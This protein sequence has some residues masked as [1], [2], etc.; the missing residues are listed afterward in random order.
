MADAYVAKAMRACG[1]VVLIG[2]IAASVDATKSGFLQGGRQRS[3]IAGH[4][5]GG[6]ENDGEALE[7]ASEGLA[8]VIELLSTMLKQFDEQ[9]VSD[10]TNWEEYSAW[11][12]NAE[13]EK[14]DFLQDQKALVMASESSLASNKQEVAK[15]TGDLAELGKEIADEQK[16]LQGLIAMRKEEHLQFEASLADVTKTIRAVVKAQEILEGHYATTEA[17]LG[18]IR[19]RVQMALTTYASRTS[20]ATPENERSLTSFLQ[21][22][23]RGPDFLNADGSKYEKYEKQGG[24]KGVLGLLADLQSQLESKKQD[25]MG[26]ETDARRQFEETK[27]S[28][29]ESLKHMHK[30]KGEKTAK[31]AECE[32]TIE[33]CIA[34]LDQAKKEIEDAKV[35]LKDLVEDR[36]K[37]SKMFS[38]RGTT[39]SQERAASQAALDALQA[40]SAGNTAVASSAAATLLQVAMTT[41]AKARLR[42]TFSKLMTLG[43]EVQSPVLIQ[44]ISRL[45]QDYMSEDQAS[46]YDNS[47]FGPVLKLL[48]DLIAKLEEEQNAETSQHEWCETEKDNSVASKTEREKNIQNLKQS[49]ES[50]TVAIDQ[51]KSEILFLQSEIERVEKETKEA[52]AIRKHEHELFLTSKTDHEEVIQAIKAALE[53]LT[54]QFSFLQVGHRQ[55]PGGS[56]PFE[57]LG[58]GGA[59]AGSA[60]EM[61]EDLQTKYTEALKQLVVDENESQKEHEE[62]LATNAQ[63]I[64]DSKNDKSAKTTER[65]GLIN[66]I[67][68]DKVEMKTNMLEIHEVNRY[69]MDLRP[70]CDDIRSTYEERK[71]RREAEISALKEA[72]EVI[73]DPTTMA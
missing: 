71:K 53:A 22:N 69:L 52:I 20:L 38:E 44:T 29:D 24:G 46:F 68:D 72:L 27:A 1:H 11:S 50:L 6:S 42:L 36:E 8:E 35:Y 18:Q 67:A 47:K 55:Q 30:V 21:G 61:L 7:L 51:L 40:V 28:K 17:S 19:A 59:S 25:L 64:E 60:M 5:S 56:M 16:S 73:S 31:K 43:K 58:G 33:Q 26:T 57:D 65:R 48:N 37:F 10:K 2:V 70:S 66:D 14:T 3:R 13:T 34:T 12:D 15:L 62:L 4:A 39:R 41:Q 32:A 45:R 23:R 54:G 49:I 9:A 63:F